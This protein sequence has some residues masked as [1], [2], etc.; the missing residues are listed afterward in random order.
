MT[1]FSTAGRRIEPTGLHN[2]EGNTRKPT[3]GKLVFQI[4]KLGILST[5]DTHRQNF[6]TGFSSNHARSFI[7]FHHRTGGCH[8]PLG[9]N[10]NFTALPDFLGQGAHRQRIRRINR[11]K[12]DQKPDHRYKPF[13]SPAGINRKSDSFRHKR[14]QQHPVQQRHMVGNNQDFRTGTLKVGNAA[15]PAVKQKTEQTLHQRTRQ[16]IRQQSAYI[17]RN[18]TAEKRHGQKQLRQRQA[19]PKKGNGKDRRQRHPQRIKN[20]VAGNY[21][22]HIS[23]RRAALHKGIERNNIHAAPKRQRK[24]IEAYS[25]SMRLQKESRKRNFFGRSRISRRKP[26]EQKQAHAHADGAQRHVSRMNKSF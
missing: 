3:S 14:R 26:V 10:H 15:H 4:G 20:I 24:Q 1:R 25:E 7:N 5:V 6:G 11:I 12:V 2:A 9:K 23:F 22:C 17:E 19:E 13:L 21:R 16:S 8:P 18:Q